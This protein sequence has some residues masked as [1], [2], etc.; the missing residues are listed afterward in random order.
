MTDGSSTIIPLDEAH[1]I[2]EVF[3]IGPQS[4]GYQRWQREDGFR[5]MDFE[6][7]LNESDFILNV[8]WRELLPDATDTIVSQLHELGIEASV[9]LDEEGEQA[10]FAANGEEV[11]IKYSI[12]DGDN[13]DQVI[14][15]IN[16]LIGRTAQYKKLRSSEGS[17]TWSYAILKNENWRQLEQSVSGWLRLLFADVR[18]H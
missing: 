16:P 2:L 12:N 9:D 15:P 3:G 10:V 5:R 13:F 11:K 7:V 1:E 17:D 8:D 4:R 14:A 6:D 18:P